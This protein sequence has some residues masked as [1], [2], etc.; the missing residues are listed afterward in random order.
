VSR[1]QAI[2]YLVA[3]PGWWISFVLVPLL[4]DVGDSPDPLVGFLVLAT[5]IC[6]S[7]IFALA[8]MRVQRGEVAAE[9]EGVLG[10]ILAEFIL[11]SFGARVPLAIARLRYRSLR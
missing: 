11:M 7:A 10:F 5:A 2:V 1:A 4:A 9:R 3:L 8:V 6:T